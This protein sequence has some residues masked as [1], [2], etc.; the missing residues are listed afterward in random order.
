MKKSKEIIASLKQKS[1]APIYFLVGEK[2]TFFVDKIASYIEENV[3][4]EEE[5]GFNQQVMYGRDV[6]MDDVIGA[7]K[8]FPMMS[9]YQVVI[10]REAQN[11]SREL[12]KLEAYVEN[13]QPST[14]L[15]FCFK[16]KKPDGRKKVIGLIKKK[17]VYYETA[18]IYENNISDWIV[19]SLAEKQ[20]SVA[21]KAAQ[22][23]IDFLGNDL[24]KIYKELE[25][26]MQ[27][28]PQ[29]SRI[30]P[31][32]VEENIGISKDYNVFELTKAIGEKDEVKA[33]KIA[34]YF[35]Q[36][37]KNNPLLFTVA[38]IFRFFQN[39]LLYHSLAD[40]SNV[41]AA[42]ELKVSPYF[43]KDYALASKHYPMKKV[44]KIIGF[45]KELDLVSKGVDTKSAT[46]GSL[47]KEFLV[48][49]MR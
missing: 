10:V 13:P 43:V 18:T 30:T 8:R 41:N 11:L 27:I 12:D 4:S 39:L 16:H 14:I 47:L 24:S 9:E 48:K 37:P 19:E 36:N 2:E 40:K 3:L 25:K 49:T 22:M 5:R 29:G 17:A 38:Q 20:Y 46:E 7:A 45:V 28:L 42:R 44:S 15:V 26:L 33:F 32:S 35:Q 23:L 6:S 1:Y 21:P 31:E 34:E